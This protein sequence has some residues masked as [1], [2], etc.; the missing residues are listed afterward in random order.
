MLFQ[1][2]QQH[3]GMCSLTSPSENYYRKPGT[4]YK[5]S[6]RSQSQPRWCWDPKTPSWTKELNHRNTAK[7]YLPTPLL[8]KQR[9]PASESS[10]GEMRSVKHKIPLISSQHENRGVQLAEV[11]MPMVR[12]QA[13]RI[14]SCTYRSPFLLSLPTR[15][16]SGEQTPAESSPLRWKYTGGGK[17]SFCL[18]KIPSDK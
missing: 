18:L 8:Q 11:G 17:T 6:N 15:T 1:G 13:L 3:T 2:L 4:K 12:Q 10:S 14:I 9:I 5:P 16:H 7:A